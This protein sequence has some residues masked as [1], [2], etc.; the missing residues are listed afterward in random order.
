MSK[1]CDEQ[2]MTYEM[3]RNLVLMLVGWAG[4]L[5]WLWLGFSAA[6]DGEGLKCVLVGI[7]AVLSASSGQSCSSYKLSANRLSVGNGPLRVRIPLT[8]IESVASGW[9]GA[10][11]VLSWANSSSG[12]LICQ[13]G[14]RRQVF[15][16]PRDFYIFLHDLAQRCPHLQ[17]RDDRALGDTAA[18]GLRLSLREG[19]S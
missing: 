11:H 6:V 13:R 14:R 1:V 7:L 5:G 19:A 16:S 12:L 18:P 2:V 4:A 15:I 8:R 10:R 9:R 17:F 3:S